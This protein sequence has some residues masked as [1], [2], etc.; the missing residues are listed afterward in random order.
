VC[1]VC[2]CG[3]GGGR[4]GGV[5]PADADVVKLLV[6][7]GNDKVCLVCLCGAGGG[8]LGG[9]GRGDGN[10]CGLRGGAVWRCGRGGLVGLS[11][12]DVVKLVVLKGKY[13]VC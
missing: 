10:L 9:G 3:A 11:D 7:K 1:L 4:G 5:G 13:K 12:A 2:L 8:E 6:R